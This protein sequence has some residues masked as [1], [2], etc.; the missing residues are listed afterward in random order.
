MSFCNRSPENHDFA[1]ILGAISAPLSFA[2]AA[3]D[4]LKKKKSSVA[5]CL[6][7]G[8]TVRQRLLLYLV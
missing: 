1:K 2:G 4:I 8:E 7:A 3:S 5:P 6:K